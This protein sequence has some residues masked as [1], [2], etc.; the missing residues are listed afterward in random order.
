[1]RKNYTYYVSHQASIGKRV[2]FGADLIAL[3]NKITKKNIEESL[4]VIKNSVVDSLVATE[5]EREK[6]KV[7]ILGFSLI[8]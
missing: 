3:E 8:K 5:E 6:V 4:N 2:I 7:V 1:M